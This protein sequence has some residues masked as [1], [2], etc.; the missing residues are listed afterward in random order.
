MVDTSIQM[1]VVLESEQ[2]KSFKNLLL[3][4]L[5]VPHVS[6]SFM[7][8]ESFESSPAGMTQTIIPSSMLLF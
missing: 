4:P 1:T 3:V 2:W 5:Y 8:S 6:K 7:S